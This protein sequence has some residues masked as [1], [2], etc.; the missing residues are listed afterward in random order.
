MFA[1]IMVY[2]LAGWCVWEDRGWVVL[3][4]CCRIGRCGVLEFNNIHISIC[5]YINN[6]VVSKSLGFSKR[7]A[8]TWMMMMMMSWCLSKYEY[9]KMPNITTESHEFK[10]RGAHLLWY[11]QDQIR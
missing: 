2:R 8:N 7:R 3:W 11:H 9:T 10:R 4:L 5:H 1:L 6:V